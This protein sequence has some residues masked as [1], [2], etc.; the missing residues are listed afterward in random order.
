MPSEVPKEDFMSKPKRQCSESDD[1]E[2]ENTST[3]VDMVV[4]EFGSYHT[5]YRYGLKNLTE[6][7]KEILR[8]GDMTYTNTKQGMAACVIMGFF[9]SDNL[10]DDDKDFSNYLIDTDNIIENWVPLP[11]QKTEHVLLYS[12]H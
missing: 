5:M 2:S 8:E 10:D 1:S 6:R 12:Y 11:G 3:L 4:Y 7:Q 9:D